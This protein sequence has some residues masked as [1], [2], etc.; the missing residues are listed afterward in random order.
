MLKRRIMA[1]EKRLAG[2]VGP[3]KKKFRLVYHFAGDPVPVA[4]P[5]EQLLVVHVVNTRG[6]NTESKLEGERVLRFDF[7][8]SEGQARR[9]N[10]KTNDAADNSHPTERENTQK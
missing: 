5:D 9:V 10:D 7:G 2:L 6:E 8:S 3:T 4:S 1:I